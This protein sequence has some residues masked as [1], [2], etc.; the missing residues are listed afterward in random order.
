MDQM[1][2]NA[3]LKLQTAFVNERK[4]KQLHTPKNVSMA[5]AGK[6]AEL[7]EPFRSLPARQYHQ[8]S[9]RPPKF[10]ISGSGEVGNR[11]GAVW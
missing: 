3:T 9:T 6:A 5:L 2:V 8:H 11:L 7:M 10:P 4:W 1:N